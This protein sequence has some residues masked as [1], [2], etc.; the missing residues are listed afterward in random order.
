MQT[1]LA[2]GDILKLFLHNI[3]A[4]GYAAVVQ[5]VRASSRKMLPRLAPGTYDLIYIDGSHAYEDVLHDLRLS[6][7]L[8]VEG[9][10]LCGDDLELQRIARHAVGRK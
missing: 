8:L 10:I 3:R 9:G 7:P 5:A 4:A 6:T 2:K 1:A